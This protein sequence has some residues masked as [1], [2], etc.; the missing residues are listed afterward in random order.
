MRM[1][2]VLI[3]VMGFL[4]TPMVMAQK[5]DYIPEQHA[6]VSDAD[7]KYGVT[8]L[9]ETY[10]QIRNNNG[11]LHYVNYW[12]LAL[13]YMIL[14][15]DDKAAVKTYL[16]KSQQLN[17][18][19]FSE[20]FIDASKGKN[21]WKGYLTDSEFETILQHS[22]KYAGVERKQPPKPGKADIGPQQQPL[23]RLIA[24]IADSD[25]AYRKFGSRDDI[26][27]AVLDKENLK[28]IDSLI[29]RYNTYIGR[30]LVG[31]NHMHVAWSVIQHSDLKT[32]ERY[33]PLLYKA[34]LAQELAA[35]CVKL[36]LDRIYTEKYGY[37]IYGTQVNVSLGPIDVLNKVR[38][39]YK[40]NDV[41][42]LK[43]GG[44]N[45]AERILPPKQ[46]PGFPESRSAVK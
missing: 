1:I 8:I 40:L 25:Q 15:V 30:S 20:I 18:Y 5:L 31:E 10:K 23:L 42:V 9:Q 24:Q 11:E 33:L 44:N 3:F 37:Q 26:K 12:N 22:R 27:Q 41:S 32:M 38:E 19:N 39:Q 2:C 43:N 16:G 14:K 36:L 46:K 7:Y 29:T 6:D 13:A 35:S 4:Y 17:L 45:N 21:I 28:R 34:A